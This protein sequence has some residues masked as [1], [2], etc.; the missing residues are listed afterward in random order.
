M[1]S[2]RKFNIYEYF[3]WRCWTL[4]IRDDDDDFNEA[5]SRNREI[6]PRRRVVR[7]KTLNG[8]PGGKQRGRFRDVLEKKKKF[9]KIET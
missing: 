9:L 8:L 5:V 1:R 4:S 2:E 7:G 3:R 6:F